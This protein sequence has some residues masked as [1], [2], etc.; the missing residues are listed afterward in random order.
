[1]QRYA[2]KVGVLENV[3]FP[4]ITMIYEFQQEHNNATH[5]YKD[6]VSLDEL[7]ELL[8]GLKSL[9]LSYSPEKPANEWIQDIILSPGPIAVEVSALAN[10]LYG[11]LIYFFFLCF[12][13]LF[14]QESCMREGA[15]I[16]KVEKK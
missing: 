9:S 3:W 15:K 14:C 11:K 10:A 2:D 16:K 7:T 1:M 12:R 8:K 6:Y 4:A 13:Q 5:P